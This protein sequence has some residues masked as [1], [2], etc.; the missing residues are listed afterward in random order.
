MNHL[1]VPKAN[2]IIMKNND[3]QINNIKMY[4]LNE[5]E[6]MKVHSL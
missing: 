6:F 3:N 2:A 4:K 5:N 1:A